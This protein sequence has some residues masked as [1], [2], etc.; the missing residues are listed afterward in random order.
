MNVIV[1]DAYTGRTE[2]PS[3]GAGQRFLANLS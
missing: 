3:A 2:S 1:I